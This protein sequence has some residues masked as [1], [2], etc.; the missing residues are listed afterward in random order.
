MAV[1]HTQL[2]LA[3]EFCVQSLWGLSIGGARA[4]LTVEIIVTAL[5]LEGW[6]I[7]ARCA[8]TA[9]VSGARREPATNIFRKI[10]ILA[11]VIAK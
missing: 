11:L 3:A 8:R 10:C 7:A 5:L 4:S 1:P 2:S 9:S 6:L